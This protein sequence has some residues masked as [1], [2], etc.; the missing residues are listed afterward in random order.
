MT[1]MRWLKRSIGKQLSGTQVVDVFER[2]LQYRVMQDNTIYAHASANALSKQFIQDG[3]RNMQWS[4][5]M[6]VK[7]VVETSH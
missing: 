7:E 5:W 6:D 1:E 2:V 4:E 3:H